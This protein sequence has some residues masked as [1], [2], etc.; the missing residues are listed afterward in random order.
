MKAFEG[1]VQEYLSKDEEGKLQL[2]GTCLV[3]GLGGK[4]HRDGSLEYYLS[5][6]VVINEAKGIA[7]VVLAY[8]EVLRLKD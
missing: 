3:A 1:I 2:G 5:E 4:T 6:P 7:P 8:T